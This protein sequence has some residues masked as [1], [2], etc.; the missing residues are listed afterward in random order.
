MP[1]LIAAPYRRMIRRRW[2][3][4]VLER[5]VDNDRSQVYIPVDVKEER[6]DYVVKAILPGVD[7][8]DLDI[9]IVNETVTIQG[10]FRDQES[11]Q[12]RYLL[13]E[14]PSGNFRRVL[15]LP[16]ELDAEKAEAELNDGVLTLRIPKAEG[17]R[18]RS[19][20]V[21]TK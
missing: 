1:V 16:D 12:T 3:Y 15:T 7:P 2:T 21:K 8:D 20:K 19:I 9:Q 13:R 17:A 10:E 4:P 11:D 18:P 6:D 14:R 5:T